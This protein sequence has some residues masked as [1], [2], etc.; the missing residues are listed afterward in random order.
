MLLDHILLALSIGSGLSGCCAHPRLFGSSAL[1]MKI[2]RHQAFTFGVLPRVIIVKT[3]MHPLN[4]INRPVVVPGDLS[5]TAIVAWEKFL[6]G[7]IITFH[8]LLLLCSVCSFRFDHLI[9]L[10][11]ISRVVYEEFALGTTRS[12]NDLAASFLFDDGAQRWTHRLLFI[13]T[14]I[15]GLPLN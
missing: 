11:Q 15:I 1:I 14:V 8:V 7:H 13:L 5:P 4:H 3:L 2:E 6:L 10:L 12:D 9:L